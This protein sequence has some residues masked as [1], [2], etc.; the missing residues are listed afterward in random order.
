M[1][2]WSRM[3]IP[4]LALL[5]GFSLCVSGCI[6]IPIGDLLKGPPLGEQVLKEGAGWLSKDKI[7]LIEID[8]VI[9]G[10][11]G[12]GPLYPMENTV[13]ETQ[14]RLR[15][16]ASDPQVRAVVIRISS[17]GGEVTACDVISKEIREFKK[18][19]EMPVL[20]CITDIGASGGY[21]VA[22]AADEVYAQPTAIVGSIGVL[23]RHFSIAD[24][25][26]KVGIVVA[27]VKSAPKKDLNSWFR[28]MTEE[29]RAILQKLVDDMYARFVDVVTEGR[30]Q[31]TRDEVLELA[32]GRVVSGTEAASLKLVDSVGY[33]TDAIEAA[34]K[35]AGIESPTLVRYTRIA[36]S[37]ANIYSQIGVQRRPARGLD[38]NLSADLADHPTLHYLWQPR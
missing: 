4:T 27:P 11:D 20:A 17:P 32:D 23:L 3:R 13:A 7:A 8:G 6:V 19:T 29:E 35:K 36:R 18:K 21:Y 33:L 26:E 38:L 25:L 5:L 24:L 12:Y 9:Q 14:A 2:R 34:R 30:P 16:A 15:L 28:P 22:V 10:G 31:L 37:G 1:K